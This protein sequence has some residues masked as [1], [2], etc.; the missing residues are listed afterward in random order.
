SADQLGELFA[1]AVLTDEMP[2][3]SI[4]PRIRKIREDSD[5]WLSQLKRELASLEGSEGAPRDVKLQWNGAPGA[6][7]MECEGRYPP[8]VQGKVDDVY[9]MRP[10]SGRRGLHVSLYRGYA[11]FSSLNGTVIG[12]AAS[13]QNRPA[14]MPGTDFPYD[15]VTLIWDAQVTE[16]SPAGDGVDGTIVASGALTY[17]GNDG[18]CRG[19]WHSP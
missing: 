1:S 13:G 19:R 18:S 17:T 16:T 8:V 7:S 5:F 6:W 4:A 15:V 14:E 3:D 9:M 12:T 10:P 11:L 2:V